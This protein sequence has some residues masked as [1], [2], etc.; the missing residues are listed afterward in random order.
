MPEYLG[1]LADSG[2]GWRKDQDKE[3]FLHTGK[4]WNVI[5]QFPKEIPALR[6]AG[7]A[8]IYT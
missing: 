6:A 3:W 5:F 1:E 2:V 8:C 4:S 7:D